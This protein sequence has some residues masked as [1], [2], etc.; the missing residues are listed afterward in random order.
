MGLESGEVKELSKVCA[1]MAKVRR[2]AIDTDIFV[3]I[4]APYGDELPL[5]T[6]HIK[7]VFKGTGTEVFDKFHRV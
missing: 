6:V 7:R 3:A 5:L 4:F 2:K 1:V